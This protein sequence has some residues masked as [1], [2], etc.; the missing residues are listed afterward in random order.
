M[1]RITVKLGG[2]L[3]LQKPY[4]RAEHWVVVRGTA[5]V[6]VD[7]VVRLVHEKEAM[8]LPI[9]RVHRLANPGNIP[10]KPVDVQVG[11]YP[12]EEAIIRIEDIYERNKKWYK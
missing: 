1:K 3:S 5:E 4:H 10:L 11:T 12:G 8:Y 7:G 2:R 9:G 6:T